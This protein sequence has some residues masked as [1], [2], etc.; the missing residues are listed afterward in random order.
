MM[1]TLTTVGYGD[2]LAKNVPEMAMLCVIMIVAQ[3][4]FSYIAGSVNSVVA[5][6][7]SFKTGRDKMASLNEFLD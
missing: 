7:T 6:Y 2:Y 5:N 4:V 1:T 3:S